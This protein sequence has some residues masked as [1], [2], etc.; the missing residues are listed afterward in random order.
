[1]SVLELTALQRVTLG[2]LKRSALWS[3]TK[4]WKGHVFMLGRR[5]SGEFEDQFDEQSLKE[6][7]AMGLVTCDAQ[8]RLHAEYDP[9]FGRVA[10]AVETTVK[11]WKLTAAGYD[12]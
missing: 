10:D 1:M 12:A 9:G 4:R 7:L 3:E 8:Q 11:Y 2:R 6:L 5:G